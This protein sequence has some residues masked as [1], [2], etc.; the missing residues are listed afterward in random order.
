[1]ALS[2]AQQRQ[3]TEQGYLLV[4][5]LVPPAVAEAA[6]RALWDA[7]HLRPDEPS[8]WPAA[9]SK[10]AQF[11]SGQLLA[12]YTPELLSAAE[13]LA[14]EE[15][16]SFRA[17]SRAYAI[18]VFPTAGEWSWPRPH[19]DHAIKDHGHHTF[20]RAFRMAAMTFLNDVP[21]HGGG[22]VVWPGSPR[23]LEQVARAD[24]DKYELMWTLNQE[25]SSLDLGL[26]VELT[27]RRG[28]VLLYGYLC[29]HAGS[30]NTSGQ[31]RFALNVKW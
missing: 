22:T 18:N 25:L 1:M 8:A 2:E 13:T 15:P 19:I 29:A 23:I 21:P 27:P 4:S 10:A 17:P 12:C 3:F 9:S 11:D 28:D 30:M 16:G 24:P 31:P 7:L 26:P 14:G 5:G 20:P 6:E